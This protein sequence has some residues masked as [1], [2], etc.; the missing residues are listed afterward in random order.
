MKSSNIKYSPITVTQPYLPPLEEFIP[1][2]EEIWESKW[3]TNNGQ[4]HQK[5]EQALCEYLGVKYISLFSNGTLALITALQTNKINGEVITTPFSFVASTHSLWW[6]GIKPVFCDIEPD[7]FNIDPDRIESLITPK[8]TA[9]MPVHVYGNPCN[10]QRIKEIADVYGLQVIYDACHAFD[11]EINGESICNWGDLSAMSFHATKVYNTFEGGAIICHDEK[12]KKRIDYLKNFGFAGETKVIAP[13][14][15][16]KMNEVQAAFGLLQL[17]YVG[18]AIEKR[19]IIAEKYRENLAGRD[20]LKLLYDMPGV[21][22]NYAYFPIL[23]KKN[24]YGKSRD[25][26]YELL[27]TNGIYTRRYFYPL[28]SQFPAYRSLESASTRNLP[29]ASEIAEQVLCLPIYPELPLSTV[30]N[31]C[32][33]LIK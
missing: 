16:A 9:I 20:G 30:E 17:K 7:T 4:F 11:V 3:L 10:V 12:T 2:L 29:V 27:K 6:N 22:H 8:T 33:I 23:I 26:V 19:K 15:N 21:K 18:Q 13:G 5:L 25:E 24:E 1:Y 14:I 28:I 32:S 31:I